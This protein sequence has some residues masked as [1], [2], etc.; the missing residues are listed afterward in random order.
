M[1]CLRRSGLASNAT[2]HSGMNWQDKTNQIFAIGTS[3]FQQI[4]M[5]E[6]VRQIARWPR[7]V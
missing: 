5:N 7:D 1:M 2:W 3:F 4:E 6:V